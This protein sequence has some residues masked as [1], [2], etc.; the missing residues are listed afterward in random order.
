MRN[1]FTKKKQHK[2]LTKNKKYIKRKSKNNRKKSR[3]NKKG[4]LKIIEEDNYTKKNTRWKQNKSKYDSLKKNSCDDISNYNE[5]I[6]RLESNFVKK[7]NLKVFSNNYTIFPYCNEDLKGPISIDK[8]NAPFTS[9]EALYALH[10]VFESNFLPIE[11]V[12]IDGNYTSVDKLSNIKGVSSSTNDPSMFIK[13]VNTFNNNAFIVSHSGFM[14]KL[15][16]YITSKNLIPKMNDYTNDY[17]GSVE[18]IIMERGIYGGGIM[19]KIGLQK[20]REYGVFDNLDILQLIFDDNGDILYML[21]R[22]YS[23]GYKLD[24]EFY[25]DQSIFK[26]KNIKSIFIMRHCLGCHNVT[27]GLT[28]KIGQVIGQAKTGKN[29]GYLDWSMC[30]EDTVDEMMIV[31]KDLHNLLEKYGGFKSYIF[32]SSV[33]FRALLT[34]ILIYNVINNFVDNSIEEDETIISGLSSPKDPESP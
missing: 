32:G 6:T 18:D 34:S 4:G 5:L 23:K 14:S 16:D 19:K 21:V 10:K 22:R 2:K 26:N 12:N 31:G 27:P 11:P 24:N 1:K 3:T 20:E 17:E 29:L 13:T 28:T 15:Y 25:L 30:F 7:N 9:S 8:V 33:I